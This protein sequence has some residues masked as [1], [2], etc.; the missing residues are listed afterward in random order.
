MKNLKTLNQFFVMQ[1][2]LLI[3]GFEAKAQFAYTTFP[4]QHGCATTYAGTKEC[5]ALLEF[6][7]NADKSVIVM[8]H[9]GAWNNSTPEGGLQALDNA[10]RQ[11]FMF[12]E[13]DVIRS[14]DKEL[15]LLHDQ[16]V[17][18]MIHFDLPDYENTNFSVPTATN[19][20]FW[21]KNLNYN[22]ASWVWSYGVVWY[23]PP[24]KKGR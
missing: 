23:M 18:R 14:W 19:Q 8:A 2:A 17:N 12:V 9:R 22:K 5:K 13:L 16:N 20:A 21:I 6:K 15:L 4:S 3:I 7:N 1:I 10:Y 24:L 11:G